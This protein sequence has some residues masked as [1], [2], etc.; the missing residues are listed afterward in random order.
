MP[1]KLMN[2]VVLKVFTDETSILPTAEEIYAAVFE[3]AHSVRGIPVSGEEF[4]ATGLN[5][6]R[7]TADPLVVLENSADLGSPEINCRLVA[8]QQTFEGDVTIHNGQVLDYA[9]CGGRWIPLIAGTLDDVNRFL[10]DSGLGH[11][12]PITLAQYMKLLRMTNGS[13]TVK[14]KTANTLQASSVALRLSGEPPPT[15]TGSLYPY[16]LDGYRWLSFMNRGGLG[17]IIADEMGLGKTVQVI[18]LILNEV[19]RG[20][21]PNLVLAP[22]TLLE[23]WRRELARFGPHLNLVIHAGSRRTGLAE[24]LRSF[25]A[26][27]ASFETAVADVS[28]FRNVH[29]N[30]LILDEAQGIRNPGAKRSIQLKTIPRKMGVAVTGTP[31]ENR[32][33]D[34]WSITDFAVP[35]LLGKLS[36]FETQHPDTVDGAALL[37]PVVSPIILRRR[38]S[39]VA[40][41]LPE[42]ID[43]PQ[44]L[45]LDAE[46]ADAYEQIRAEAATGNSGTATITALTKL[47]MFCTHPWIA[48]RMREVP[49]AANCSVKFRRL[50]EILEEII[51]EGGKALIFTSYQRSID[52][53]VAE[54]RSRMGTPTDFI[55]G[56]VGVPERQQKV[57]SFAAKPKSAVLVLN[58]KAAGVGLNI[59][60]ANHVIHYNLE[61]NPAVEDQASARAHRRGQTRPVT[62]HRFFY[63]N[64]VEE[65]ISERMDRKRELA[66][67]AIV[68][69][70]GR[71]QEMDDILRA[72]RI[73]PATAQEKLIKSH[74]YKCD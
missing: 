54:I 23:N 55:D 73:S 47:R 65:V 31:V 58:P 48:D 1:V 7:D 33:S 43:I 8:R 6:S 45:E 16:Q 52:L 50:F 46:S 13:L 30:L 5:F 14:D 41:D 35:G 37:E 10:A 68:G 66:T 29:W 2:S 27:I 17:C 15:F 22:A 56:R 24:G 51:A 63:I 19:Q 38:V 61:W 74:G 42:R 60:A 40:K 20:H 11:F 71:D 59:T 12:G 64:T 3:G 26:V 32:L 4:L 49:D 28:L 25:D 39:D 67:T 44:P 34:L 18:C 70:D 57:D 36:E 62:V 21:R 9:I 72:L 69:T 53:L